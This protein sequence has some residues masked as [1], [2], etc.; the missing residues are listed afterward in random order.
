MLVPNLLV[1]PQAKRKVQGK[2]D[3]VRHIAF[4]HSEKTVMAELQILSA[5]GGLMPCWMTMSKT[6]MTTNCFVQAGKGFAL[7]S[8]R[9]KSFAIKGF[10]Q[11]SMR[12]SS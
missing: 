11:A 1:E 6:D 12:I 3:L 2:L 4:G 5:R 9:S 10:K 8:L 7:K